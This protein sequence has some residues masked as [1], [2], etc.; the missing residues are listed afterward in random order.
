MIDS[1]WFPKQFVSDR[2]PAL[3]MSFITDNEHFLSIPVKVKSKP[4]V[5]PFSYVFHRSIDVPL[6]RDCRC[7]L[8]C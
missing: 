2:C 4:G 3:P 8:I 5:L 1:A 6:G 7:V